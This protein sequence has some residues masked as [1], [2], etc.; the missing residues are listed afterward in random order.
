MA[1]IYGRAED[2]VLGEHVAYFLR[3]E[4]AAYVV[5]ILLDAAKFDANH[6][7]LILALTSQPLLTAAHRIVRSRKH[8]S[9]ASGQGALHVDPRYKVEYDALKE[10]HSTAQKRNDHF[11]LLGGEEAGVQ[12]FEEFEKRLGERMKWLERGLKPMTSKEIMR[13]VKTE[14]KEPAWA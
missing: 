10:F 4:N 8:C 7:R 2:E 13:K 6:S 3:P 11:K 14:M 9:T 1:L 5:S 12:G